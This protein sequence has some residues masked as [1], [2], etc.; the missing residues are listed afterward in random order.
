MMSTTGLRGIYSSTGLI[1]RLSYIDPDGDPVI[2][3]YP[4]GDDR[5]RP[6]KQEVEVGH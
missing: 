6:A 1:G 3:L 2:P 4:I 5:Y